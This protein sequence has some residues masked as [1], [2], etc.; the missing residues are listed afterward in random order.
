MRRPMVFLSM[1]LLLLCTLAPIWARAQTPPPAGTWAQV[2]NTKVW[3][4]MAQAE[5][6]TGQNAYGPIGL[7][8]YSGGDLL[9]VNGVWGFVITGG[10]HAATP[11]NS[12]IFLPFDGS[13]PRQLQG[14]YT[15]PDGIYKYDVPY[16]VYKPSG[17]WTDAR[18]SVHTYSCILTI[19]KGGQ[20]FLF[21]YGGSMYTGA[22]GGTATTRLFDLAQTRAQAM[23]RPDLGWQKV[24]SAPRSATASSCVWDAA[25]QRVAVR[26]QSFAGAYYPERD[27][28]ERWNVDPVGTFCCDYETSAA[29][30]PATRTF[31]VLGQGIAEQYD[32]ARCPGSRCY[33]DLSRRPWAVRFLNKGIQGPGVGWHARTKQIVAWMQG[34]DGNSL[35]L[36]NPA[37]DA[38]R[39]VSMGGVTVSKALSA[40]TYGRFR[41][42][43]GT[44]TVVLVNSVSEN[45]FIGTV[46]FDGVPPPPPPPRATQ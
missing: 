45:V 33:A 21:L 4:A 23:A 30:D 24:A 42:I 17:I 6:Y 22:G 31:Y 3:D 43:P 28:W 16:D 14:P 10:G 39:T 32:L 19:Q 20:P 15:S 37:T 12:T 41:V 18:K 5:F 27:R 40:G 44:D 7:F 36:I 34:I 26:S 1:I 11:D 46:P 25:G 9:Q 35:T 2:P 38:F 13:G 29:F 8:A